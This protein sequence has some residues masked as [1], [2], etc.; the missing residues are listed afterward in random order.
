M[1]RLLRCEVNLLPMVE[2]GH[3]LMVP[4]FRPDL[5]ESS[6]MSSSTWPESRDVS[7]LG[8]GKMTYRLTRNI[9]K[10]SMLALKPRNNLTQTQNNAMNK[11]TNRS[12]R[13]LAVVI[14][15]IALTEVIWLIFFL[16]DLQAQTSRL[17]IGVSINVD[18]SVPLMHI[19]IATA[20]VIAAI[21]TWSRRVVGLLV[22]TASLT[23]VI[24]EYGRWYAWSVAINQESGVT[25]TYGLYGADLWNWALVILIMGLLAWEV[26]IIFGL[27]RR[28]RWSG[29]KSEYRR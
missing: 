15:L 26:T 16:R 6:H 14:T 12:E 17:P 13:I 7:Q 5:L 21:G 19:R 2:E 11:L 27:L 24:T 1:Q 18:T 4:P 25:H 28:T 3:C 8:H 10:R 9:K 29:L 20:L 22:S 23:W